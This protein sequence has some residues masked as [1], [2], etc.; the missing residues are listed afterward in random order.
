VDARGRY[1]EIRYVLVGR[2]SAVN[3]REI[4]HSHLDQLVKRGGTILADAVGAMGGAAVGYL[5]LGG[6]SVWVELRI[7][8]G[9]E[10][11]TLKIVEDTRHQGFFS[12]VDLAEAFED[13]M[14]AAPYDI[15]FASGEAAITPES[16]QALAPVGDLLRNHPSLELEVRG[17]SDM[18]EAPVDDARLSQAR[19]DAVKAYL[20]DTFAIAADRLTAVGLGGLQPLAYTAVWQDA[21]AKNRRAELIKK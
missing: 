4:V 7:D 20:V 9:C 10:A 3:P 21:Q 12:E 6:G 8:Q 11:Y 16:A 14:A 19:A 13:A 17:H 18:V 5:P 1:W 2:P 15:N